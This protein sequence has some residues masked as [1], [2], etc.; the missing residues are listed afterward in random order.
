MMEHFSIQSNHAITH[1]PDF[2]S[3]FYSQQDLADSSPKK[4]PL[5]CRSPKSYRCP[6][7]IDWLDEL[8]APSGGPRAYVR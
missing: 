3:T 7:T 1:S 6:D 8:R 5:K 4:K 2:N